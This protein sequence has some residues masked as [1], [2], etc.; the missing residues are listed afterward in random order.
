MMINSRQ[1]DAAWT[2]LQIFKY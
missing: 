1:T 2:F